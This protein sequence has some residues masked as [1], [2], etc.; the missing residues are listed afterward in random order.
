M[1]RALLAM[2]CALSVAVHARAACNAEASTTLT[3]LMRALLCEIAALSDYRVEAIEP[4]PIFELPQ[5]ELEAK[6]CDAPC[7][8]SAAYIPRE[9]IFL[10][11][12]LEPLR[13]LSDRAAL[14]HELVHHLQQGHAK[15]AHL[16]G[17]ARERAKEEEA[18]ALQNAYLAAQGS[19][20]R[21]ALYDAE[22]SCEPGR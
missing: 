5:H 16:R 13:D 1:R 22:L 15:F 14:L 21:A 8:V 2:L 20:E 17:C 9:G 11:G 3:E 10:A 12:N 18:Y 7:N 4:P 6:V 19:A